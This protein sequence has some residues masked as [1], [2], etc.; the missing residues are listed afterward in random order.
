MIMLARLGSIAALVL[1]CGALHAQELVVNGDFEQENICTEYKQPCSPVAWRNAA[2]IPTGYQA[3]L[4]NAYQ[5]LHYLP[6][7]VEDKRIRNHRTYWQ[8]TLKCSMQKGVVYRITFYTG[9]IGAKFIPSNLAFYFSATE[10][11]QARVTPLKLT[12]SLKFSAGNVSGVKDSEWLKIT[13]E[14]TATGDERYLVAGNFTLD[15]DMT[16]HR[17]PTSDKITYCIDMLSIKKDGDS[18]ACQPDDEGA[19]WL[20]A[21]ERHT[22][23]AYPRPAVKKDTPAITSPMPA[24][25]RIDTLVLQDV[26]FRFDSGSLTP[27]ASL[28]LD[29]IVARLQRTPFNS[30]RIEGHT[31][32][33]GPDAYN[34]DLSARRARSVMDYFTRK[35][36]AAGSMTAWGKGEGFP[37]AA[38]STDE[39]RRRNRRV[40]ILIT[41]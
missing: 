38:N 4:V 41:Y 16:R 14:Y 30:L 37:V 9:C 32:S 5:G 8:T 21:R 25:A 6:M 13:A 28:V 34:L 29:T 18:T 24:P 19:W 3:P 27:E 33:L 39:G 35:G 22:P 40:E 36:I 17:K 1:W 7:V 12:P 26:L 20:A 2:L 31:D 23:V 11:S 15:A 10:V